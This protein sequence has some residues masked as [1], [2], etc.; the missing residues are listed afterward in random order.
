MTKKRNWLAAM[1]LNDTIL[2]WSLGEIV[3]TVAVA[4]GAIWLCMR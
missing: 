2:G 4:W 1:W 3:G